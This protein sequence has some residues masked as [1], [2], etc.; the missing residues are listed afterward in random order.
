MHFGGIRRQFCCLVIY[1]NFTKWLFALINAH[2]YLNFF[3]GHA[4]VLSFQPKEDVLPGYFCCSSS[5]QNSPI[6]FSIDVLFCS[7]ARWWIVKN[8][9]IVLEGPLTFGRW[10]F[11][12]FAL[13]SSS[14]YHF[15]Y[16]LCLWCM[17]EVDIMIHHSA[18]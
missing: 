1:H 17:I 14:R 8:L 16:V 10:N 15:Q 4:L 11:S 3:W 7:V 6:Y 12:I 18:L 5:I 2:I 9:T 13:K